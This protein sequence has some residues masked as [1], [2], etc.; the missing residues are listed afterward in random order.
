MHLVDPHH[1]VLDDP[2]HGTATAIL[3]ALGSG[4]ITHAHQVVQTA[5]KIFKTRSVAVENTTER[6]ITQRNLKLDK[7]PL[8][9]GFISLG[10]WIP[11]D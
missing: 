3:N 7:W 11:K 6:M 5:V 1:R 2:P 9:F 4:F 8:I 10:L